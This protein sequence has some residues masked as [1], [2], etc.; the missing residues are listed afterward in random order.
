MKNAFQYDDANFDADVV[1]STYWC[2]SVKNNNTPLNAADR[3]KAV[4]KRRLQAE[5]DVEV[6]NFEFGEFVDP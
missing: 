6:E 3:G 1:V 4:G 2:F 5:V